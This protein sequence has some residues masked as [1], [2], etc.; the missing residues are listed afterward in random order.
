MYLN[1]FDVDVDEVI[2]EAEAEAH[3]T[4]LRRR[5]AM[6][7]AIRGERGDIDDVDRMVVVFAVVVVVVVV[8]FGGDVVRVAIMQVIGW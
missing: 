5:G 4:E 8:V 1:A 2:A 6:M 3:G 7:L